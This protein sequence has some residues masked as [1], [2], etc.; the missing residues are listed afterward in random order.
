MH[1]LQKKIKENNNNNTKNKIKLVGLRFT[2][3]FMCVYVCR[4]EKFA[5]V[6][7]LQY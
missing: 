3:A 4:Y 5:G 1:D 7:F 6:T 2:A